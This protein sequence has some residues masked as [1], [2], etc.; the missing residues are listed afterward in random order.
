MFRRAHRQAVYMHADRFDFIEKSLQSAQGPRRV[1]T[2]TK[3]KIAQVGGRSKDRPLSSAWRMRCK[4]HFVPRG[5]LARVTGASLDD[6]RRSARALTRNWRVASCA[7][8]SSSTR[9]SIASFCALAAVPSASAC[10]SSMPCTANR[11]RNSTSI[12]RADSRTWC[13][14]S[15]SASSRL[16]AA[17]RPW[18]AAAA[19]WPNRIPA[20]WPLAWPGPPPRASASPVQRAAPPTTSQSRAAFPA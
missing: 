16:A 20:P 15:S 8:L 12:E 11:S 7:D 10:A 4:S 9:R 19:P 17:L 13:S 5:R 14:F 6:R 3:T 18:P 1:H 2:C